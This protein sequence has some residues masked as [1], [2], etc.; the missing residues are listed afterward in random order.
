MKKLSMLKKI[1]VGTAAFS[2]ITGAALIQTTFAASTP[3]AQHQIGH[4]HTRGGFMGM[5][6]PMDK[7]IAFGKITAINGNTI[8][9]VEGKKTTTTYTV[10]ASA[11]TVKVNGTASTVS[12]LAVNDMVMIHATADIAAGATQFTAKSIDKGMPKFGERGGH[13]G[14]GH[15]HGKPGT[16][17]VK[18]Q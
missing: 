7:S 2:T 5:R 15:M 16:A 3:T 13:M 11:A 18:Q 10:D 8:T 17:A 9:I 4:A 1:A 12:A 6:P 14:K